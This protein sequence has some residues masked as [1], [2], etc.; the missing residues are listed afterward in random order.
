[1]DACSF[2][3]HCCVSEK[4]FPWIIKT[5]F[6]TPSSLILLWTSNAIAKHST[7]DTCLRHLKGRKPES[8][9][10]GNHLFQ[11]EQ[12]SLT[13]GLGSVQAHGVLLTSPPCASQGSAVQQLT[14]PS[15]GAVRLDQAQ[16]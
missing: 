13:S 10:S 12:I 2:F 1:M 11:V 16:V 15:A 6:P 8:Q 14:D 5:D 4:V 9:G 7:D 3:N